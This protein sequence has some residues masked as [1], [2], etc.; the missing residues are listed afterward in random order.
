MESKKLPE[1]QQVRSAL[2]CV[3]MITDADAHSQTFAP[4][5]A[6]NCGY[7]LNMRIER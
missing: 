1:P 3:E 2:F 6:T 5:A 4:F 7:S